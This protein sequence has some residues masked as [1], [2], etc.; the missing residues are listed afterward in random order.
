MNNFRQFL[1]MKFLEWQQRAGGRKTVYEFADYI[2]V[3]QPAVS[4]W[5][6]ETRIPQG[7]NVRK[8]AEKLGLEVYDVLGLPR[9]DSDLFYIQSVWEELTVET[10]KALREKVEEYA[11]KNDKHQNRPKRKRANQSA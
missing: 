1:E 8:L 10:R 4:S 2:G 7:D 5:W 11:V 3:S 9:P 6:N